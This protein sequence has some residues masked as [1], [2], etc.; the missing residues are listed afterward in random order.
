MDPFATKTRTKQP[1]DQTAWQLHY[2]FQ[3]FFIT[4]PTADIRN[5]P[6]QRMR[7]LT[8]N[9]HHF[10]LRCYYLKRYRSVNTKST[11]NPI[12]LHCHQIESHPPRRLFGPRKNHRPAKK[13]SIL[14][15]QSNR[16][17]E[18]ENSRIDHV[19]ANIRHSAAA[20]QPITITGSTLR[21]TLSD[22]AR[23]I[24]QN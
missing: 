3:K 20:S 16:L 5:Y 21:N 22:L 2:I 15:K 14:H 11:Q 8:H 23:R 18:V 4:A 17:A 1:I 19:G 24:I 7:G 10:L 9:P 12:K 6:P 13:T